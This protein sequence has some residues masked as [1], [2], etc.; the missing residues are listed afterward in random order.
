MINCLILYEFFNKIKF[1]KIIKIYKFLNNL[2][3]INLMMISSTDSERIIADFQKKIES[4][5][6]VKQL[7]FLERKKLVSKEND[8]LKR[9]SYHL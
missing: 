5:S 2:N 7:T 3:D 4:F 1:I 8:S 9:P 6:T